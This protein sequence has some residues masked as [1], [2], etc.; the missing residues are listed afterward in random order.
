MA[1]SY[2]EQDLFDAAERLMW[3][4]RADGTGVMAGTRMAADGLDQARENFYRVVQRT[5][6]GVLADMILELRDARRA[7]ETQK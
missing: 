5:P 7:K 6:R 3:A 4:S 2:A 1:N